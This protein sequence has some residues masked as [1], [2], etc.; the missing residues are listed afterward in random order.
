MGDKVDLSVLDK[1]MLIGLKEVFNQ[2]L[3]SLWMSIGDTSFNKDGY[4]AS[5][6]YLLEQLKSND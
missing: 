6:D 4:R 3:L 5:T 2:Y 1:E